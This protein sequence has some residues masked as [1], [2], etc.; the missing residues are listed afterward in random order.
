MKQGERGVNVLNIDLILSLQTHGDCFP[1]LYTMRLHARL[2]HGAKWVLSSPRPM[3][4][5][6]FFCSNLFFWFL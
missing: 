6:V 3:C 4:A 1:F 2:S 5:A